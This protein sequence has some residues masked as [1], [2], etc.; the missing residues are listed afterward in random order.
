MAT[1]LPRS[2][3][4]PLRGVRVLSLALNLPG[5]AALQRCVQMGARCSKIEPAA[6]SASASADPMASYS[7]QAYADLHQGVRILQ[8]DLKSQ[9]GQDALAHELARTH[10]LLTSFRPSALRKLGLPWPTLH[11]RYPTLSQVAIVGSAGEHAELPGH[12][13][14]YMAENDLVEGL[15]LPPTLY[16]DMGG[17][18]M[19]SEGVLQVVLEARRKQTG[20]YL[21]VALASAARYVAL[22]RHWGLTLANAAVGGSHAG[23]RV[24]ACRDGRVAVAAL[25]AHFARAL[26]Q[27]AGLEFVAMQTMLS[28]KTHAALARFFGAHSRQQLQSLAQRMDIPLHTLPESPAAPKQPG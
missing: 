26:C 1:K 10:V 3:L 22:P 15:N 11:R 9:A 28:P 16:A 5:P 8:A 24:Y 7:P 6:T 25:E 17:A 13:L 19:A 2:R 21:E 23:Y 20:Q 12:D 4:L 14:T 27:A 18:L